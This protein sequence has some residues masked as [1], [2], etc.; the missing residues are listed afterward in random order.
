MKRIIY[1][2]ALIAMTAMM[3]WVIM[4]PVVAAPPPTLEVRGVIEH[5]IYHTEPV[6]NSSTELR[7]RDG[8]QLFAGLFTGFIPRGDIVV[9]KFRV[10][11]GIARIISI[12]KAK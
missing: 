9:V 8:S 10:D 1:L 4:P 5:V 2:F 6:L 7:F 12:E 3:A 11:D